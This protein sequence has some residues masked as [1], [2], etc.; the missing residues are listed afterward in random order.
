VT[1]VAP[2]TL[3]APDALITAPA[4]PDGLDTPCAVVDLDRLERNI[5]RMQAAA[6]RSGVGLR[7]HAKTHKS[8][9]VAEL[10]L[11]A[12]AQGL[13]VGTLGEAEVFAAAGVADLFLAYP[14]W[15]S[16][17]KAR[18]IRD[19]HE[20]VALRVAVDS[21]EGAEA[22]GRATAGSTHPLEVLVELDCG[23]RR[24]GARLEE[25]VAIARA[26]DRAG[27]RTIGVATYGGHAY[28]GREAI[29]PA[30]ADEVEVVSRAAELLRAAGFEI[31]VLSV[32]STPTAS[33]PVPPPVTEVR[34]GTYVYHDRGQVWLGSCGP[35]D[36]AFWVATTVT[37]LA[38]PGQAIVDAGAK[39]F[40]RDAL[41]AAP[42]LGLGL[43]PTLPGVLREV[44][45]YHGYVEPKGANRGRPGEVLP[46][47]PNHVCPV[48]DHH[49]ETVMVRAGRVVD[50]WAVDARGRSR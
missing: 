37:S 15:A 13:T 20:R 47:A 34:P 14:V 26:A 2:G 28:A 4:L 16:E 38:V 7:P 32:G 19:L 40:A 24:T 36:I 42:G 45:D 27:L 41:R 21:V 5:A 18:R 35:D 44:N 39:A 22:L 23:G 8:V 3:E 31:A 30:G 17:A 12:G 6:D 10:Q 29:V 43:L 50:V 11:A 25:A 48:V 46:L 9:K 33:L 1:A 49:A